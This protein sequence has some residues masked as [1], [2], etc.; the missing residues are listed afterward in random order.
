MGNR[1]G[2]SP[3]PETNILK[4]NRANETALFLFLLITLKLLYLYLEK[5]KCIR[6]AVRAGYQVKR[7][8]CPQPVIK[9]TPGVPCKGLLLPLLY[10]NYGTNLTDLHNGSSPILRVN[11]PVGQN[12]RKQKGTCL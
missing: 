4:R 5:D 12:L 10:M 6:L 9:H 8:N 1:A 2:S 11:F 7:G 3:A